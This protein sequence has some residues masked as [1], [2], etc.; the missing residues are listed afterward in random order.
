MIQHILDGWI[1]F[2]VMNAPT[3]EME[4]GDDEQNGFV[5]LKEITLSCCDHLGNSSSLTITRESAYP[6]ANGVLIDESFP[7][8]RL[9]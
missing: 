6:Q 3:I 9:L 4:L 1:G 5:G 2:V 8:A 7:R